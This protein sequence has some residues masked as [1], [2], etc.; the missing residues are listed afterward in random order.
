MAEVGYQLT[1]DGEDVSA[2]LLESLQRLEVEEHAA[3][4]SIMRLTFGI[5]VA[6]GGAGWTVVDDGLF[7]RFAELALSIKVGSGDPEPLMTGFVIE[8]RTQFAETPGDSR[9]DVVAM[10]SSVLMNLE[11]KIRAWPNMSDGDIAESIFGEYGLNPVVDA[12]EP[13]RQEDDIV[14][15]QRGTDIQFLRILAE[16]NGFS[17]FVAAAAGGL[18]GHFH[19]PRLDDPPQG[20]LTVGFD[21]ASNVAM[22][23]VTHDELRPT[24]ARA[25]QMAAESN[26]AQYGSADSVSLADLGGTSVLAG[27]DQRTTLLSATGL[28]DTAELQTFAQ[29]VVDRASWAIRAEGELSTMRYEGVLRSRKP[30]S[31]RGVGQTM[32]GT[33]FVERV[34]HAFTEEGYT[35]QF[36]LRR[37]ALNLSGSEDFAESE[38]L[39][40]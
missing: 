39:A 36:T 13:T 7:P 15:I 22:L 31:V 18:E 20:V 19:A 14:P 8:T 37:N 2:E 21:G 38:A 11:E 10:D 29:A 17:L 40:S 27:S 34:L 1:I 3:M 25:D 5:A 24:T 32:S 28:V 30:V 16:R 12:T 35:Q 33:Y 9:I 4:A 23:T 6:E 26:E